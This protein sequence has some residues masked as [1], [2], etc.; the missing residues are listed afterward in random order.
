VSEREA[1][2]GPEHQERVREA[3]HVVQEEARRVQRRW[4]RFVG[5]PEELYALGTMA[6]YRA[7]ALYEPE[8]NPEFVDYARRRV[9]GAMLDSL[10][11]E[12]MQE[13]IKRAAEAA[14]DRFLAEFAE[15]EFTPLRHAEPEARERSTAFARAVLAAT[16]AGG[17]DEVMRGQGEEG[18]ALRNEYATAIRALQLSLRRLERGD[19]QVILLVYS[20]G[21]TLEEAAEILAIGYNTARRWHARA[22]ARL[23]QEME[24]RGVTGAPPPMDLQEVPAANDPGAPE[25][26]GPP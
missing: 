21:K 20:G 12:G 22:L 14:A 9:R 3:I 24:I 1:T 8:K 4:S 6:L 10:R 7:A 2:P 15:T 19:V 26:R 17:V 23:H 5:R 11:I 18:A 25:S 13:R 16:F